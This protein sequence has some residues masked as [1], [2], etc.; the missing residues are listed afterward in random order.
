MVEPITMA[1]IAGG[2]SS[3]GKMAAGVLG[4]I[5]AKR[6][7]AFFEDMYNEQARIVGFFGKR[8]QRKETGALI[9]AAGARGTTLSSDVLMDNLFDNAL[10]KVSQ[11][12]D[13]WNRALQA[14]MTAAAQA[15][16]SL[17]KGFGAALGGGLATGKEIS[18]IQARNAALG[19]N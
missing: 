3:I 1:A 4:A 10:S 13:L 2:A 18:S 12:Q 9:S 15:E 6:R 19:G 8:K 17:A 14:K 11:Q 5:R 16:E 7:G